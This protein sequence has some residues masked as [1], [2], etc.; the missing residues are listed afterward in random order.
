[1][2][3]FLSFLFSFGI[4]LAQ[5]NITTAGGGA[6]NNR[7]NDDKN[8]I[9]VL[10]TQFERLTPSGKFATGA[11]LGFT[12]WRCVESSVG[13]FIKGAGAAYCITEILHQTG[14]TAKKSMIQ[15][16]NAIQQMEESIKQV[17]EDYRSYVRRQLDPKS[18]RKKINA[19]VEYDKHGSTGFATGLL[20][21]MLL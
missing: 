5:L 16:D 6:V 9:S 20:A 4:L 8:I 12:G 17:S 15:H 21:G 1:M 3:C 14:W 10:R 18:L 11:F 13:S 19:C 7:R 2:R